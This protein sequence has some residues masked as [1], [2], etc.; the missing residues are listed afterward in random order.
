MDMTVEDIAGQ[1]ATDGTIDKVQAHA[2]G[3]I[4]D[5]YRMINRMP[6]HPDYL[7]QRGQSLCVQGRRV[8]DEKHN[9]RDR[10]CQ[11]KNLKGK[12]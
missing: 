2:G 6:G 12:P 8:V 3:H 7:L 1:F 9:A 5:S 10:S 4:N 11:S